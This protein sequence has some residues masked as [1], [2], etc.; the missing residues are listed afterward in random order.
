RAALSAGAL[1]GCRGVGGRTCRSRLFSASWTPLG[2]PGWA[3]HLR[4]RY[5][6][7]HHHDFVLGLWR[8][9]FLRV[10]LVSGPES[11]ERNARSGSYSRS[12]FPALSERRDTFRQ[13][14]TSDSLAT[15]SLR[16]SACLT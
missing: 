1:S 12:T 8:A 13:M 10:S 2:V 11:S 9:L 5:V 6:R 4:R 14:V 15:G 16:F 3:C 7:P